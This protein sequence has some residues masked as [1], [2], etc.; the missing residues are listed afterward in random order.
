MQ[1]KATVW[2]PLI[3]SPR[4]VSD[5][6]TAIEAIAQASLTGDYDQQRRM[7]DEE[8]ALLYAYLAAARADESWAVRATERLNETIERAASEHRRPGLYGG[9]CGLGWTVE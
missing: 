3:T 2:G 1:T 8:H 7:R 9:L 6:W 5:A 4:T